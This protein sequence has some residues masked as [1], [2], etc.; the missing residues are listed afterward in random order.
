MRKKHQEDQEI[1]IRIIRSI[2]FLFFFLFLLYAPK[3]DN[4]IT[5]FNSLLTEEEEKHC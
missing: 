5:K 3:T 4:N 1:P 2:T